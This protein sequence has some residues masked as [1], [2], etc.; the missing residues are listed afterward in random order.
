MENL[1]LCACFHTSPTCET[2]VLWANQ[3]ATN[4]NTPLL[5]AHWLSKGIA[6]GGFWHPS[7]AWN[8]GLRILQYVCTKA[9]VLTMQNADPEDVDEG[10][11]PDFSDYEA[12]SVQSIVKEV[13]AQNSGFRHL[14][15]FMTALDDLQL[16]VW[17]QLLSHATFIMT[18]WRVILLAQDA[19]MM[20]GAG[21]IAILKE[22]WCLQK[23]CQSLITK[24]GQIAFAI[25]TAKVERHGSV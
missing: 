8:C 3:A 1:P 20:E 6:L 17:R 19:S 7:R 22:L 15:K 25:W 24:V 11:E 14:L 10:D 2:Q 4:W 9:T 23:V 5:I 13:L 18:F 21:W 16:Q 12:L